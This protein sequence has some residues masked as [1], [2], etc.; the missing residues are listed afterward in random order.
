ML[1]K[2][3]HQLNDEVAHM[4]VQMKHMGN[5]MKHMK[6][7]FVSAIFEASFHHGALNLFLGNLFGIAYHQ[8]HS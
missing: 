4:R 5:E 3:I 8:Y 2:G 1:N 6:I 7:A